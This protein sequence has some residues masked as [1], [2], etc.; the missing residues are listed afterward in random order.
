[1][2]AHQYSHIP[3]VALVIAWVGQLKYDLAILLGHTFVNSLPLLAVFFDCGFETIFSV[4]EMDITFRPCTVGH[5]PNMEIF[6]RAFKDADPCAW[7][8]LQLHWSSIIGLMRVYV[9]FSLHACWCRP[10][11]RL[12]VFAVRY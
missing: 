2:T 7:I 8:K 6:L 5:K 4:S 9:S 11:F 1:M 3:L 12:F 10:G